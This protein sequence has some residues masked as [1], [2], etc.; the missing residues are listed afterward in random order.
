MHFTHSSV[1]G[2]DEVE[3]IDE[4][5]FMIKPD[6]KS[7]DSSEEIWRRLRLCMSELQFGGN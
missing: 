3:I 5:G 6:I 7:A 2:R 1:C 4:Y